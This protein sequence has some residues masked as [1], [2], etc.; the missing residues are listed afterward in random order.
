MRTQQKNYEPGGEFSPD[1]ESTG[2]LILDFPDFGTM[3]NKFLLPISYP[4]VCGILLQ[5]A[6]KTK[7]PSLI[8]TR[9]P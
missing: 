5:Q 3:R 4:P 8:V 2:D 1:T 6:E 9:V 7:T